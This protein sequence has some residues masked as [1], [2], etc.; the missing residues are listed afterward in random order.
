M[1]SLSLKNIRVRIGLTSFIVLL[2]VNLCVNSM[3]AVHYFSLSGIEDIAAIIG[4]LPFHLE[5]SRTVPVAKP[6]VDD[7][8]ILAW[9]FG[10]NDGSELSASST[11]A[12]PNL[13]VSTLTRG[14]GIDPS[15]LSDSFSATNFSGTTISNAVA[16]NQ[17]FQITVSPT[18]GQK[19]SLSTLNATFRRSGTPG[20]VS[21]EI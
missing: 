11:T 18:S 20:Y 6:M 8:L 9:D 5:I 10:G 4:Q 12:D 7:S 19:V 2:C 13:N 1:P 15:T 14:A 17:Y 21:V 3:A 16:T